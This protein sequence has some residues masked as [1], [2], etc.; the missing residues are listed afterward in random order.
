MKKL[1][2]MAVVLSA[3][4]ACNKTPEAKEVKTAYIDTVKLMEDYTEAKELQDKFKTKGEVKGRELELEARKLE[5][6]KANFQQNAMA[7]GQAWAQQK[8]AELQQRSQ[9]LAYAEQAI[10]QQLQAEGGS[11]RDSVVEK[12]RTFI[13]DYGKKNGYDYIYG[14][15]DA[16]S[17]LYA[18]DSY[19]ITKEVVKALN[20]KYTSEGKKIEPKKEA[21]N[22]EVKK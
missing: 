16:A 4:V 17:V 10:A 5:A 1:V 22:K 19:D 12:V 8:Y 20:E 21:H 11:K 6:E 9:Q 2:M 13:K 3:V 14:T 18:K 15:G 7:K